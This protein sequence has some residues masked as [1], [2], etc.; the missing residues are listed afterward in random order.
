MVAARLQPPGRP[1]V[2]FGGGE[3]TVVAD[4][5]SLNQILL[6]IARKTGMTI[7]GG[8]VDE[9]VYGSYGPAEPQAVLGQLLTGT[10][11]NMLL[12]QNAS[13]A[14]LKLV[15]TP[16]QGGPTPPGPQTYAA[17]RERDERED[18]LP[19]QAQGPPVGT[20]AQTPTPQTPTAAGTG[21]STAPVTSAANAGTTAVQSPNGVKTPQ[22]IYEQLM[23]LQQPKPGTPPSS[24]T[25]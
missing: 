12:E 19:P 14:P 25:Q 11:S 20:L 1:R 22:Q 17:L 3:L 7:T 23:K 21:S 13:D 24:T 9:R 10:G 2:S 4:N 8:V 16:R 5:S 6:E 15:L 18:D